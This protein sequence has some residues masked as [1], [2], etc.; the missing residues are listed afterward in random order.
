MARCDV[1]PFVPSPTGEAYGENMDRLA[2]VKAAYDPDNLFRLNRNI[3]R[4]T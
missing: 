2:K 1:I 3:V 4:A